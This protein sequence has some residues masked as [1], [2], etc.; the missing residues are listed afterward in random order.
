VKDYCMAVLKAFL[1]KY[2]PLLFIVELLKK[3]ETI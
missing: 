3:P 1:D 2:K